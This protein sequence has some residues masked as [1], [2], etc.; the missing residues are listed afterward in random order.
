[1]L[2][3]TGAIVQDLVQFKGTETLTGGA[4]MTGLHDVFLAKELPGAAGNVAT[5]HQMLLWLGIFELASYCP[6]PLHTQPNPISSSRFP[7]RIPIN[8]QWRAEPH[9]RS[10]VVSKGHELRCSSLAP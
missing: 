2:A 4:K 1:M 5:F 8:T 10:H 9:A 7:R 6:I 3:A